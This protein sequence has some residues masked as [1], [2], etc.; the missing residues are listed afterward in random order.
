MRLGVRG[1]ILATSVMAVVLGIAVAALL[2]GKTF[3]TEY[4]QSL[5]SEVLVITQNLA[6]Q[7]DRIR[8]LGLDVDDIKG[9]ESQC[10]E[11]VQRHPDLAYA[12]VVRQ[13]GMVLFHNSPDYQGKVLRQLS[14]LA[15]ATVERESF[16]VSKDEHGDEYYDVAIPSRPE[17]NGRVFVVVGFPSRMITAKVRELVVKS[18]LFGSISLVLGTILLLVIISASVTQPLSKLVDTIRG[19]HSSGDLNRR[20]DVASRDEFGALATSFNEMVSS[21]RKARDELE[22]RVVERT[23][24]LSKANQDLRQEIIDRTRAERALRESEERFRLVAER[25]GQ[26]VFDLDIATGHF[27]WAGAIQEVLGTAR[28]NSPR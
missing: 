28:R 10:R 14:W 20:V 11:V 22:D 16:H 1:K 9:F 18:V 6:S 7:L 8:A 23:G 3:Q 27:Q 19:I 25:T 5:R 2:T 24:E 26:I 4:T 17:D 12:M 13:D 21:L 15:S